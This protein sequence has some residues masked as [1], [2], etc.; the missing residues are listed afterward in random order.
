MRRALPLC[1][2]AAFFQE[3]DRLPTRNRFRE[4]LPFGRMAA[5]VVPSLRF[6]IALATKAVAVVQLRQKTPVLACPLSGKA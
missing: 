5:I 6:A 2:A 3:N 4:P 1:A